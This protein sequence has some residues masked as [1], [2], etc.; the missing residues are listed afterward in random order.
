LI[1]AGIVASKIG[2]DPDVVTPGN[3]RRIM[4]MLIYLKEQHGPPLLSCLCFG[5]ISR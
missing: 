4:N 5:S 2:P 3:D 1:R